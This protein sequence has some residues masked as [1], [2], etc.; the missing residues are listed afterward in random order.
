MCHGNFRYWR[1]DGTHEYHGALR[2]R[3]LLLCL[4]GLSQTQVGSLSGDFGI[5][6]SWFDHTKAQV[7]A[8]P[9]LVSTHGV[10]AEILWGKSWIDLGVPGYA[11]PR[12]SLNDVVP[13]QEDC[14]SQQCQL[15][16][17]AGSSVVVNLPLLTPQR[18]RVW[19]SDGSLPMADV[20]SP[21]QLTEISLVKEYRPRPFACTANAASNLPEAVSECLRIESTRLE[22][23]RE[24]LTAVDWDTSIVRLTVFDLLSHLLGADFLF[25]QNLRVYDELKSFLTVLDLWMNFVRN[26]F[27]DAAVGLLSTVSHTECRARVN[28]NQ[29]LWQG[30]FCKLLDENGVQEAAILSRRKAASLFF[31]NSNTSQVQTIGAEPVLAVSPSCMFDLSVTTCASAVQGGIYLNLK[32]R[33]DGG[34]VDSADA[35]GVLS[36]VREHITAVFLRELDITPNIWQ[37]ESIGSNGPDLMI[38]AEGIEFHNT[39][40]GIAVDR[41]N[42]PRSTHAAEGFVWLPQEFDC[43]SGSMTPLD[44]HAQLM[45]KRHG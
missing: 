34:I 38:Y 36:A 19:L 27:P 32:N 39:S 17:S 22:C 26:E 41:V 20:F 35:P 44:F 23:A 3:L 13:L 33:Y 30:G 18:N 11:S 12:S 24:L 15:L 42:K 16:D 40:S 29:I 4:E 21:Q 8:H 45:G 31:G 1:R 9:P 5:T 25:D 7:L 28:L 37:N 10:W 14:L 6:K 2:Q 43:S